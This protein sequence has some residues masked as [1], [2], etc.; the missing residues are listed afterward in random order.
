MR[1][2]IF[3]GIGG[4]YYVQ[5]EK[6]IIEAKGR[7][8]FKKDGITLA[9][10]DDVEITILEEDETKGVIEKIYPRKNCFIR[11]PIANVDAF[12]VVFA[13]KSPAP[14]FPVIDKFLVNAEKHGIEPIICIN[15]KDLVSEEEIEEIKKIYDSAYKV[16]AI[17][18]VTGEGL[19]EL[20][21]LIKDKK[22]ALAGPSGVGKSS[23]LNQLHPSANMETGE[24][25]KKTARGKHTTRHVEIFSIEQGGMIYDTPGF[26][27]FEM[28][29]IELDELK[30]Y[31][32][33]FERVHGQCKYDNCYHLKEPEC[34][35][36]KAVKAG[37]IHILRYKAYLANMEEIKSKAK[38]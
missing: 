19:E 23:I 31:Y 25:S 18:T 4:F 24:V 33:E 16:V 12:I 37:E 2:I 1:G 30:E 34:A 10:G 29:D 26:T 7:G 15:K 5:T 38:Y 21:A 3:K 20:A 36:R 17:S 8:I 32:P 9:V 11:P 6:G 14:N 27:S 22:A 35:V 13:A 28:P